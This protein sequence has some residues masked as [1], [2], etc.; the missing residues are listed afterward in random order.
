MHDIMSV[1]RKTATGASEVNRKDL[2]G[3]LKKR[4]DSLK[5]LNIISGYKYDRYIR[6]ESLLIENRIDLLNT[7]SKFKTTWLIVYRQLL[8]RVKKII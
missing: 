5:H 1:Y 6:I 3:S 8:T 2:A 4:I 7:K